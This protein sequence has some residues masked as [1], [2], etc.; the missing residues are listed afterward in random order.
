MDCF[1][2]LT[3]LL[4]IKSSNNENLNLYF[5]IWLSFTSETLLYWCF[6]CT[7][8]RIVIQIWFKFNHFPIKFIVVTM[9]IGHSSMDIKPCQKKEPIRNYLISIYVFR[10]QFSEQF[11]FTHGHPIRLVFQEFWCSNCFIDFTIQ[12]FIRQHRQQCN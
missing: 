9:L 3:I 1:F 5:E 10:F 12:I 4:V 6:S 8:H 2:S 11:T 7:V